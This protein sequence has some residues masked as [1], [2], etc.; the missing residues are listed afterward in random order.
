[1]MSLLVW[2]IAKMKRKGTCFSRAGTLTFILHS[3]FGQSQKK[4]YFFLRNTIVATTAAER[5]RI[6]M[7]IGVAEG[8]RAACI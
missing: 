2:F 1:M 4:S 5:V 6:A 7:P 8:P 3:L